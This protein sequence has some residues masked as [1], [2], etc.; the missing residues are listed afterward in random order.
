MKTTWRPR[1]IGCRVTGNGYPFY[2]PPV[3][4]GVHPAEGASLSLCLS[5][6][7]QLLSSSVLKQTSLALLFISFVTSV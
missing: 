3:T 1:G 6:T 2:M 7:L 4:S 5:S